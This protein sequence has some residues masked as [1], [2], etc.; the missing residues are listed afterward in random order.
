[1]AKIF[2]S[3]KQKY[4]LIT[5]LKEN[6]EQLPEN[7]CKYLNN[8]D[9]DSVSKH[10]PFTCNVGHVRQIRNEMFGTLEKFAADN[11]GMKYSGRLYYKIKEIESELAYLHA[12]I[13][14]VSKKLTNDP[15]PNKFQLGLGVSK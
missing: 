7:K 4:E 14:I 3:T 5:F 13:N 12:L 8:F 9:D 6:I 1:M 11:E 15:L 10:M 2:L